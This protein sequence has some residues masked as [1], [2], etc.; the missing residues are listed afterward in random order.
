MPHLTLQE[1]IDNWNDEVKV[2]AENRRVLNVVLAGPA[3]R[4]GY[5]YSEA[6][7]TSAA[8]LYADKPVFLDHAAQRQRPYD[9]STRDLVGSIQN[10]RFIAGKIRGDIRVLDT[11][12]GQL[13]LKLVEASAPGVGMSHVVVA[14]RSADGTTVDQIREVISVDVVI[15]PATTTTFSEST[16]EPSHIDPLSALREECEQLRA[17]VESLRQACQQFKTRESV[18]QMLAASGL[19]AEALTECFERQLIQAESV[20]VRKQLIDDRASLLS[21]RPRERTPAASLPRTR[22]A[23]TND[24]HD[25]FLRVFRRR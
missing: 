4:N 15:N 7:L 19:P 22:P 11:E 3:S 17:E 20:A 24:A 12:N 1:R 18:R 23:L 25:E 2:D 21:G 8:E 14:A 6:A 13:F 5:R 10:P 16:E 9:R